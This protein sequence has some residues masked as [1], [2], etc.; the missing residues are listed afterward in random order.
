VSGGLDA[1]VALAQGAFRLDAVL[2]APGAGVTAVVGPSGSGKSTLLRCLAGLE[3][4]ALGRIQ[5]GDEIWLDAQHGVR[6]PPHR[7][8]VAMVFQDAAPFAHLSVRA[9]LEYGLRRCPVERRRISFDDATRSLRLAPLL[10]RRPVGL[11]GGERQRVAIARALLAGPRLV[12][13]DEPLASLDPP[14]RAEILELL[15]ALFSST[16]MPVLYVTH[17]R[18]EAVQLA[19]HVVV[20]DGGRVRASGP[21]TDMLLRADAPFGEPAEI[22]SVIDAEVVAVDERDGI[23]EL[24]FAGGVLLVSGALR[25]GERRRVEILARDVSLSLEAPHRTSILNVLPARVEVVYEAES[26][27]PLVRVD[28]S[29]T[30]LLARVSRRSLRVLALQR[31]TRVFAQVKA[32]AVIP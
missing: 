17:A 15:R 32:V 19:D 30:A 27:Q 25:V 26:L 4:H 6:V 13:L 8:G 24:R 18:S 12:L 28:V 2:H 9:N 16:P 7:R 22:G 29:G 20:M 5:L 11:S 10:D 23:A 3:S 14:A 31:G 1:R 21:L